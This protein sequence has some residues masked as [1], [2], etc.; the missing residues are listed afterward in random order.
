MGRDAMLVQL[1]ELGSDPNALTVNG[2]DKY[3]ALQAAVRKNQISTI[4]TLIRAGADENLHGN[5]SK[6]N[7]FLK[8]GPLKVFKCIHIKYRLNFVGK[9]LQYTVVFIR[10][11]V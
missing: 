3:T 2:D 9:L 1:L 11:I 6:N 7:S 10:N 4:K 8:R 5:W